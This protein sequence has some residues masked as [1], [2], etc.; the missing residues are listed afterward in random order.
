M[1]FQHIVLQLPK[2]EKTY[3]KS[4][5]EILQLMG[6]DLPFDKNNA[7]FSKI[8]SEKDIYISDIVHKT[9]LKVNERGTEAAAVIGNDVYILS[10]PRMMVVNRPFLFILRNY[11]LPKHY[12]IIFISKIEEV[13]KKFITLEDL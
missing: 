3:S 4:L 10:L 8:R 11:K 2:F 1:Q 5:K 9:Y 12:D 6:V 7:D 13:E